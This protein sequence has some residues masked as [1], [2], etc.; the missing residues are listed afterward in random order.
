MKHPIKISVRGKIYYT[1]NIPWRV[2]K[3]VE[4]VVAT[5]SKVFKL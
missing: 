3:D 2:L 4:V 5:V 1:K